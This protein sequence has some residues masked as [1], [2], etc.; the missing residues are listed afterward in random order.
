MKAM[1]LEKPQNIGKNPLA[2]LENEDPLPGPDELLLRTLACALCRTDLQL[3]EGDI[4]PRHLPIVPGHQIVGVVEKMGT[5]ANGWKVGDKA[6]VGWLAGTCGKCEFCKAGKENLCADASFTGWDRDGGYAQKTTV[7]ADF[8]LH[9]PKSSKATDLAPLLCG[10]VIGYR[11]LKRCG[12]K[13]GGKLGLY[14]YGASASLT[15]QVARYWGC[16]IYVCTR[17][18]K[19]QQQAL[20]AGAKWARNYDN[21]PPVSLDAVITFTPTGD[22]IPKA[23]S[24]VKRG[25]IVAINAIH[26]DRV[27]EFSYD[28]LWWERELRSVANA[29]RKDAQE[30]LDLASNIQIQTEIETFPLESANEALLKLS[31]GSLN[32]T[33][34]L[35]P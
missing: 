7:R 8:A 3:I 21:K 27:P 16:E 2:L 1:L 15:I 31:L 34:V 33:A 28:L 11:A 5:A 32:K 13:P 10:G 24:S 25:G 30:F 17:S 26:L 19:E 35:V 20:D 23:L 9:L 18:K 29:T 12:I 14:G 6:G 4:I 22:V